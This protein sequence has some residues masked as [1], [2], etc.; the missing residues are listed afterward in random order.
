MVAALAKIPSI[1]NFYP[2]CPVF[3]LYYLELKV[4]GRLCETTIKTSTSATMQNWFSVSSSSSWRSLQIRLASI[5]FTTSGFNAKKLSKHFKKYALARGL[6]FRHCLYCFHIH[7]YSC[8]NDDSLLL[9][10]FPALSSKWYEN[11]F[12]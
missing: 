10:F 9:C 12:I 6:S 5:S 7:E 11:I 4:C 1:P 8:S 2:V 3:T